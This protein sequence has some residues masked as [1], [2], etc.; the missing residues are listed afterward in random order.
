VECKGLRYVEY[1]ARIEGERN[2]RGTVVEKRSFGRWYYRR[3][4]SID[5]NALE[6]GCVE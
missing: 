3:E 5:I 6:I 2:L 1:I 4:D